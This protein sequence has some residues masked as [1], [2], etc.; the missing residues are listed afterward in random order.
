MTSIAID[1]TD[2]LSSATAI[3]GPCRVATTANITLSGEQ[4]IDGVAV[5]TADRV[6]VQ[7]QTNAVENG[8]YVADTGAWRRAKDFSGNRDIRKGTRITVTDGAG[9]GDYQVTTSNPIVIDTTS[10]AFVSLLGGATIGAGVGTFLATPTSANLKAAVTDETGSGA[11]VFATSATLVTPALGTPASGVM[12]NV[13]GLPVGTGISGLATNMAAW[14]AGGTSAQL[15][16]TMTDET[17][18]G[19]LVF[20]TSPTLVTPTIGAAAGTSLSLSGLTASSAVATDGSKNLVSVTNTGSGSNVLA[21]SPTLVTPALGTPSALVLT[22]ATGLP[23]GSGISGLA[24]G[25]ATFLAAPSSANLITAITDETG[26]GSL[27]FS[28]SATLVTPILGVATATSIN[29]VAITAP[30]TSATLTI[31]DGV[32]LTGPA[33]SG[34]AMTLGNTE[35]V[36]GV[37]TFGSAG[38]VG[39]LKVA[40]TTSGTTTL[41]ASAVAS[42]TLT[43]PAATD[44]L[45][46]KATTDTLTNKTLDAAQITTS[47]NP[48]ADDGAAL[49][50][51][52]KEWSD[53][54]LATGGVLNWANGNY[55]V[56]HTPGLLT[57]SAAMNVASATASTSKTTGA[58]VVAGGL[59]VGGAI[60]AGAGIAPGP[61]SFIANQAQLYT[62]GSLGFVIS[63]SN[64]SVDDLGFYSRGG[65]GVLSIPTASAD[66]ALVRAALGT[67]GL[68]TAPIAGSHL[69]IGAGTTA[70]AAIEFTAGT[71]KTTVAAGDW[72]YDGKALYFSSVASSR[73]VV[74]AK[75]I[76]TVQ[77]ATVALTNSIT[78]AQSIFAAA[79]DA[80]TVAA[81]TTYRFRARLTFNT[82]ATSHTTAFGFGGTATFTTCNYTSQATS[83]AAATL[84]TPQMLRVAV[85][86]A[87]V[88]TAASIAVTTDIILEGIIR[89]NGAGTI[90]PQITFSAGPT[91]TCET[92]LD[93]YFELEPIGSNTVAAIGNW[94]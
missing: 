52:T 40:G 42:G 60:W 89:I 55:A 18:S 46:G 33:S 8:I 73:Q 25:I 64:G 20:A 91:G 62:D 10:L 84:A 24:A 27:V 90:I 68:G 48:T 50:S 61:G 7:H 29:K 66:L 12:T 21:T 93:S 35:T 22:N 6:L 75:Q 72:E 15:A 81:A 74:T 87:T 30:A 77:N 83:S 5:V 36:T 49:G 58:L 28:T 37:K 54:F 44:T 57:F 16:A 69:V 43:L 3:K 70:K 80:L 23:V 4:T 94:A 86:T 85:A 45:V 9:A 38:A 56:T 53:L 11:L 51:T 14:L 71:N 34:T 82:G 47:L 41:D 59:G 63:A 78:T 31:P 19:A 13:T 76:A 92:A 2:G 32:T 79:N 65:T 67:V 39:R 88:L 1:L 17:G 26:S